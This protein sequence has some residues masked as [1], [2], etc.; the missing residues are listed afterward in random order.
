MGLYVCLPGTVAERIAKDDYLLAK[1]AIC[2]IDGSFTNIGSS[3]VNFWDFDQ[4]IKKNV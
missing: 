3:V 1:S 2:D 4:I